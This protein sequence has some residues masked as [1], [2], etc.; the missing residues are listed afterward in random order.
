MQLS[1]EEIRD[2]KRIIYDRV[3]C[4][5]DCKRKIEQLGD[6]IFYLER[7]LIEEK[8]VIKYLEEKLHRLCD[9]HER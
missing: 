6:L 4:S 2:A 7:Q 3:T 1:E 5:N 8:A 9:K